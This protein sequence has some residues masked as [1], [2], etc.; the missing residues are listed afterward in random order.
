MN[1]AVIMMRPAT[2][3]SDE[4]VSKVIYARHCEGKARSNPVNINIPDCFTSFAMTGQGT[5]KA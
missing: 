5:P 3:G 1:V 4:A 2:W